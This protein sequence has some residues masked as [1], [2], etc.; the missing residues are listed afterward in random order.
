M[1]LARPACAR[2]MKSY[3]PS[4]Q[5]PFSLLSALRLSLSL[6]L[7]N[8]LTRVRHQEEENS[9][10]STEAMDALALLSACAAS[11]PDTPQITPFVTPHAGPVSCGASSLILALHPLSLSTGASMSS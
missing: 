10:S 2:L 7:S 6:S 4:P 8:T 9:S 3:A 5:P 1:V 11:E